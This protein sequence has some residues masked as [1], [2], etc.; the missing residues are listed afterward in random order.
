[1]AKSMKGTSQIIKSMAKE[2]K[3]IVLAQS[4]KGTGHM[5]N[6]MAKGSTHTQRV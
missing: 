6:D 2:G 4:M 1:M 5:I 3:L